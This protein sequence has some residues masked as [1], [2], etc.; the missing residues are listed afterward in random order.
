MLPRSPSAGLL[1]LAVALLL[2]LG[3]HAFMPRPAKQVAGTPNPKGSCAVGPTA[4]ATTPAARMSGGGGGGSAAG[5][6]RSSSASKQGRSTPLASTTMVDDGPSDVET[7]T[8]P[9]SGVAAE[10]TASASASSASSSLDGGAVAPKGGVKEQLMDLVSSGLLTFSSASKRAAVNELLLRLEALNPT[11]APAYSPLLNGAW[12]FL[13]TGGISPGILGLQLASRLSTYASGAVEVGD[14]VMTIS[15]A[16]P[17]VEVQT[18][19]KVFGRENNIK[20]RTRLEPASEMR[21]DETYVEASMGSLNVPFPEQSLFERPLFI[22]YLDEELMIARD[23]FGAPD[24]L[25]RKDKEFNSYTG[26]PSMS[27]DD[28]SPGA[29]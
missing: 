6:Y 11:P 14:T 21:L 10:G 23:Q 5:R 1:V 28:L 22:S 17:R 4:P 26:V 18:S 3:S 25:I 12:E 20:I 19:L 2:L 27:D 24:V 9:D 29:G 7:S 8:S 16:Q 13:Y 15:R